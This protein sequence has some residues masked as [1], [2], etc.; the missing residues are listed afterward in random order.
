MS[1][2]RSVV[3]DAALDAVVAVVVASAD[4]VLAAEVLPVVVVDDVDGTTSDPPDR[5]DVDTAAPP[6]ARPRVAWAA[7]R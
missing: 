1:I 3:D 6:H 7:N 2:R 5:P 4:V